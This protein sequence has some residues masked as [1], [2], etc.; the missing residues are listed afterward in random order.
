MEMNMQEKI[1]TTTIIVAYTPE[2]YEKIL[3]ISEDRDE[4][5]KNWAQWRQAVNEKRA[6]VALQDVEYVEQ[7]ID[8]EGLLT[9]CLGVG[10]P[11]D[12]RA[13]ADYAN[14]LYER[15]RRES[16]A[17][18]SQSEEEA[19]PQ[20]PPYSYMPPV[21]K[22]LTFTD[23]KEANPL[24]KI[25]YAEKF[26]IGPEHI[27]ELIRM[28]TDDYLA[29]DD[30]NNFEFAA[31]LHA[32]SALAELHAEAAIEPLLTLYDKASQN[33]NEWML[34]T[35]VHVFTT[36]GPVALPSIEQFLADSSHE[37]FAQNY[38]TEIIAR[39]AKKYPEARTE[40]MA[41]VMR[42]LADFKVN[43]PELNASLVAELID[44]EAVEAAPLIE[45]AYANDCVDES[46]CGDWEEVQYELG[47]KERP[48][49]QER[50][51][52]F[53]IISTPAPST[54]ARSTTPIP[55]TLVHKSTKK[56]PASKKAKIKMTKASKKANRRKK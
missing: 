25:S 36:I 19:P 27:P 1:P 17:S 14:I 9:Y 40:C 4:I 33:G 48:A 22:L 46:W 38:V 42:R 43:N 32:V 15:Q 52:I 26:G 5:D 53:P 35:L 18:S 2:E 7:F 34:E 13:R 10:R 8:L 11:I 41:V 24:P 47:L 37:D 30:S 3:A 28:A 6:E 56:S 44:M 20:T 45:E 51:S 54:P 21:D 12:A 55:N 16:I 23:I 39:I 29:G 50:S 31:P 49:R